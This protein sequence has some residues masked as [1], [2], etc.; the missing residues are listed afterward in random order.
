MFFTIYALSLLCEANQV[1]KLKKK[2]LNIFFNRERFDEWIFARF[3]WGPFEKWSKKF[4]KIPNSSYENSEVLT[5]FIFTHF[6]RLYL[7]KLNMARCFSLRLAL[8]GTKTL[9]IPKKYRK[10]NK[11]IILPLLPRLRLKSR[12]A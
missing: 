6:Y 11:K 4:P 1:L 10:V 8:A 7:D 3:P 9:I 5:S 2:L 12:Y